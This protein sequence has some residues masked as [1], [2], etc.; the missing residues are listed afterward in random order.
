PPM[1]RRLL[2]PTTIAVKINGSTVNVSRSANVEPTVS[3]VVTSHA[4]DVRLAIH[5]NRPPRT[6]EATIAVAKIFGLTRNRDRCGRSVAAVL[7]SDTGILRGKRELIT[8]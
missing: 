5:P 4:A 6:S 7:V 1:E 2:M 8:A 3:N